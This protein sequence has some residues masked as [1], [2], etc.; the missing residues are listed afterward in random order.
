MIE[1]R[2]GI[3]TYYIYIVSVQYLYMTILVGEG[4]KH[5]SSFTIKT[6][7][8]KMVHPWVHGCFLSTLTACDIVHKVYAYGV[9]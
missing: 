6:T 7:N 8:K 5:N 9:D 2:F 1:I 4:L 3:H